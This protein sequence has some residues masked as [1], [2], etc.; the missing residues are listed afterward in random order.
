MKR[1]LLHTIFLLFLVAML[2]GCEDLFI[3]EINFEAETEP[4]MMVIE[5]LENIGFTPNI[6]VRHS[7][8]FGTAPESSRE[9]GILKDAEV[10]IRINSSE[11]MQLITNGYDYSYNLL[12]D[13]TRPPYLHSF[14]TIELM[15]SYPDYQTVT[16]RQ[17]MPSYISASVVSWEI[18]PNYWMDIMLELKPYQGNPDDM[19]GICLEG[20][21]MDVYVGKRKVNP[22][23]FRAIYSN[24]AVFAEAANPIA[25]GYYGAT[26]N[27]F[28]FLPASALQQTRQIHLIADCY[29][30]GDKGRYT[31]A[32]LKEA[33]LNVSAYTYDTYLHT[34]SLQLY[35][36]EFERLEPPSGLDSSE[37]NFMDEIL[38]DIKETLGQQEPVQVYSNI[39]NGL[40]FLGGASMSY[41]YI[42]P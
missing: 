9:T 5:G 10:K 35:K 13:S 31:Q 19:I 24:D 40:G 30:G 22:L 41:I 42:T 11:W 18:L 8:F 28:L 14:D 16:A 17:I 29:F 39:N 34:Q 20:G 26:T 6:R 33:S 15:V 37:E 27:Q 25:G 7:Y 4:Q 38:D 12:S 21:E 36:G 3:R 32:K 23:N 2:A 1:L